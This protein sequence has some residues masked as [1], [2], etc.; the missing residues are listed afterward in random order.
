MTR[1]APW[2]PSM[3]KS[4]EEYKNEIR[5][6]NKKWL[7]GGRDDSRGY[8]SDD[9]ERRYALLTGDYSGLSR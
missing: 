5:E 6:I 4:E 2:N 7:E 9:D 1:F 3:G 8:T